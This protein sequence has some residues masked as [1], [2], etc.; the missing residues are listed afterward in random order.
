VTAEPDDPRK[1]DSPTDLTKPSIVYS[2][3]MAVREFIRDECLDLAAA[4]TYYAVLSLFPA[5]VVIVSLLG[6]FGQGQRT[7]DSVLQI[8]GQVVP[9]SVVETLRV[10][11]QQ[12]VESP[13][14]GF[15]LVA[16]VLGALW[17]ASGYIGAFGRAMNRIY[18]IKEGRPVWKLRPLQLLITL[19]GLLMV[20]AVAVMLAVSGPV[21]EAVGN[22]LGA[23]DAAR[24]V[25]SVA[26]WP[27]ILLFVICAVAVL[28]YVT[29]NVKQ[30]RFRWVSVGAATAII[31]WIV[32]SIMFGV[33]VA[34]FGSYNKTYGTLGGVIVFLLWLWITNVA[35][36]LGAEVDSELEQALT[37]A[38]DSDVFQFAARAGYV[39]SGVL[40]I[41]IGYI[42]FHIAV[43]TGGTAD[44]SG[45]LATLARS[46]GGAAILWAVA[47]GLVALGFWR[48]A[49]AAVGQHPS[50][51]SSDGSGAFDRLNALALAVVYFAIAYSAVRF[52]LGTGE[53]SAEQNSGLS[54]QLMQSGWGKFLLV[55]VGLVVIAV[56]GYHVYKGAW[57]KFFDDLTVSGGRFVKIVG[58]AGF[59]AKGLVLAGAG[60]LVIVAT[61]NSDPA[62][63]T[64]LDS[65]VK[66]LGA[67]PFG[68]ALLIVAA[69]G[70]GAF[71][72]YSF[73]RSRYCRL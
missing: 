30:P 51:E 26:R 22:A 31:I 1:P 11:I 61:M 59:V 28:Y 21:A 46:T 38:T 5:M 4:L 57:Q 18:E 35:L 53:Q 13:S 39:V 41:L 10:P 47:A 2:L 12:L 32:A 58:I 52:A 6:V 45:A 49:E 69:L 65:A 25:W 9:A 16:G 73:V 71:G 48:L 20:A 33:Y 42:V 54:A 36:L 67:A 66:T 8:A 44:Q 24:L 64:G 72:V 40:H 62:K 37:K 15:A 43:G 60:I 55:T 14:A 27:L 56:G 63:A 34:H 17:S 3:R 29:P 23:G 50:E 7:V 68:K 70:F 19:G